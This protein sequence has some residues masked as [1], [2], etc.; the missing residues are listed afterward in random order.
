MVYFLQRFFISYSFVKF[1]CVISRL[2]FRGYG[3]HIF[4]NSTEDRHNDSS[5]EHHLSNIFLIIDHAGTHHD[6]QIPAASINTPLPQGKVLFLIFISFSCFGHY[7]FLF[8]LA[9]TVY[10]ISLSICRL[11]SCCHHVQLRKTDSYFHTDIT[12]DRK[13]KTGDC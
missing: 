3:V 11:A 4:C 7:C 6:R 10:L 12:A 2:L 1:V 8:M 5:I 13:S 9:F